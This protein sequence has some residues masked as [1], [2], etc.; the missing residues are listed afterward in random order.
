MMKTSF[1]KY[2][3]G[4]AAVIFT[5]LLIIFGLSVSAEKFTDSLNEEFRDEF[6]HDE[7]GIA[8]PWYKNGLH[9]VDE[10][11]I[12]ELELAKNSSKR[13]VYALGSS[14]TVIS[15]GGD[16]PDFGERGDTVFL[17]CGNGCYRSDWVLYN[18]AKSENLINKNDLVK[19]EISF[20][21]FRD[22]TKTI[23]EATLGKW[24]KYT[25]NDDLT[26]KKSSVLFSPLWEVNKALLKIQNAWELLDSDREQIM[27]G[28]KPVPG[29]F[30]NNYFNYSAVADS[31][32]MTDEMKESV[33]SLIDTIDND[34]GLV[35][36]FSPLPEG[37]G[38]TEYGNELESYIDGELIPY[39]KE[40]N[41]PYFD[42][43]DGL[44]DEDF[45]DGVHLDYASSKDYVM[46]V[47]KDINTLLSAN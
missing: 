21:T 1:I 12:D 26:V 27:S 45:A 10:G 2:M 8:S 44:C 41:I 6:E 28:R 33:R 39:L 19:L 46:K 30:K 14:L 3:A 7:K 36:E 47:E 9:I 31:C 42:Y 20:S 22:S 32:N 37:L 15:C 43:R 38:D 35:I 40:K 25:V 18:L 16:R 24:K 5:A 34:C 23:T 13:R 11:F 17:V 29:N 4:V